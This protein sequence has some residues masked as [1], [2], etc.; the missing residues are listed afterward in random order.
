[1]EK[2]EAFFARFDVDKDNRITREELPQS[3]AREVFKWVDRTRDDQWD[4]DEFKILL[5]PAG[6]SRNIMVAIKTGGDGLLNETD[7]LAWERS[8]PP[9]VTT[10]LISGERVY[11]VKSLGVITC[12]NSSTG[13]P[14][15]EGERTG[16][17]DEYYASPVKVGNR[18][19]IT[20][21]L[22]IVIILRDIETFEI[23]AKN[24]LEDEIFTPPAVAGNTLYIRSTSNPWAFGN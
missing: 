8:N 4:P 14:Y 20:S 3:Q 9:Y 1:M 10:P 7:C 6:D 16:V 5:R 18:I 11:L 24:N 15:F 21:N 23:L 17:K 2:P 22:G 12:L 13:A 19:F